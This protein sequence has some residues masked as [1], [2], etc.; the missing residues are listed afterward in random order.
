[1]RSTVTSAAGSGEHLRVVRELTFAAETPCHVS[2]HTFFV[3]AKDAQLV[4][5]HYVAFR[6]LASLDIGQCLLLVNVDEH[7]S[8]TLR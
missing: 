7:M 3:A 1:M 8:L 5:H 4:I 6:G 2:P